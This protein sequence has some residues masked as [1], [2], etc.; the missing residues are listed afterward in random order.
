[1]SASLQAVCHTRVRIHGAATGWQ[2]EACG[3]DLSRSMVW[4]WRRAET[5]RLFPNKPREA[6]KNLDEFA[7]RLG[8]L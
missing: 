4:L 3:A 7:L 1:M 8:S 6:I 2:Q 5:A